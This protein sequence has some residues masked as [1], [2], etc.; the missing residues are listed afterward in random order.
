MRRALV[1][2]R[3]SMSLACLIVPALL[4]TA[5][6]TV[7]KVGAVITNRIAVDAADVQTYLDRQYPRDYDQLGGLASLRVLNPRVA[8]PISPSPAACVTTARDRRCIW[9]SPRWN[10]P[11]CRCSADA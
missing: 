7:D 9:K 10:P 1:S 3:T 6:A 4:L 11:I 5:C 8:I 2:L